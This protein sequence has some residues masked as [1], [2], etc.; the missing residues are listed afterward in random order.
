MPSSK[1]TV[2][3]RKRKPIIRLYSLSGEVRVKINRK[4]WLDELEKMI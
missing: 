4:E 3:L 2:K 1:S